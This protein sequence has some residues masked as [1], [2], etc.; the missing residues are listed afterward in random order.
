MLTK[1]IVDEI[2]VF[3]GNEDAILVQQLIDLDEMETTAR[4]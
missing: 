4:N 1:E 3:I 2:E